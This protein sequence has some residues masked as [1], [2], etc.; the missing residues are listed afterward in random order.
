LI[1]HA[2]FL[3][4][5]WLFCGAGSIVHVVM[6]HAGGV[7]GPFGSRSRSTGQEA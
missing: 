6:P 4:R 7:E 3:S 5:R 2:S 1:W